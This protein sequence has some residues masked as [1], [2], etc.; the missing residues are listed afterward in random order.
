[1]IIIQNTIIQ[2]IIKDHLSKNKYDQH[3]IDDC[4]FKNLKEN[5][6]KELDELF[7]H[8]D[9]IKADVNNIIDNIKGIS[10]FKQ[11]IP[12]L[13]ETNSDIIKQA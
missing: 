5:T 8:R 9:I 12:K 1:M 4:N 13:T 11:F 3:I 7:S 2:C 10:L 6:L